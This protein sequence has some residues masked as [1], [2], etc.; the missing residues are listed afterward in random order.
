MSSPCQLIQRHISGP[1]L[2]LSSRLAY[3]STN[4]PA[5]LECLQDISDL[6]CPLIMWT[7]TFP[8]NC[9]SPL[10]SLHKVILTTWLYSTE[11]IK[12]SRVTFA[13]L[14]SFTAHPAHQQV[15]S[16]LA[17][18]HTASCLLFS[19]T[20]IQAPSSLA[21]L[22]LFQIWFPCNLFYPV[23][24]P[25]LSRKVIFQTGSDFISPPGLKLFHSYRWV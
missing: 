9:S 19:S 4:L 17:L 10:S 11:H 23:T 5:P 24:C 3:P 14:L 21:W 2:S 6:R 22:F 18:T 1:L 8:P 12:T 7:L 16:F 25:Y 13:S 15:L 20:L